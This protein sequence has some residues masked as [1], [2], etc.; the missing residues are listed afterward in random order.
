VLSEIVGKSLANKKEAQQISSDIEEAYGEF[1]GLPIITAKRSFLGVAF[2]LPLY[3][4]ALFPAR[5]SAP[6]RARGLR[7]SVQRR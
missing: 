7:V 5:V 4:A 6:S 3:G 1:A 2:K